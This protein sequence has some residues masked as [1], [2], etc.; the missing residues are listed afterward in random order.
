V[1][2]G[3]PD[4]LEYIPPAG[5]SQPVTVV[6]SVDMS[7]ESP[8]TYAG[9]VSVNGT[10]AL[11]WNPGSTPMSDPDADMV[12]EAEVLYDAG[13]TRE[14]EFKFTRSSNGSSW[15]W[16]TVS[17][18]EFVIDDSDT[19]DVLPTYKWD[20]TSPIVYEFI[21][22]DATAN[23]AVE[24]SDAIYVLKWLYVPGTPQPDCSDS[25]DADDDGGHAM[26]DALYILKY[27]YVPGSPE[28][29][30]PFPDCGV[31]PSEDSLGCTDHPCID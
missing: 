16:E 28:P 12:Y 20:S 27:L 9:G 23:G 18:R 4:T 8:S 22:A 1:P 10:G 15:E 31:D 13:A 14:V 29:P 24:M 2:D 7:D 19:V 11:D 25:V 6:F 17:N 26:G 5:L 3:T 21:R 30:S